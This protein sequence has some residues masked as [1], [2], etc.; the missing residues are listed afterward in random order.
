YQKSADAIPLLPDVNQLHTVLGNFFASLWHLGVGLTHSLL[1]TTS[2]RIT[3]GSLVNGQ[4]FETESLEELLAVEDA[5]GNAVEYFANYL[6][7]A[8]TFDGREEL[9]E[10]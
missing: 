6:N 8:V 10:Y 3:L 9:R 4:H 1:F 5:I 7:L 2:L